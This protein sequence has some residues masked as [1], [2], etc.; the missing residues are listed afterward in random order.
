MRHGYPSDH[1]GG[2][3]NLVSASQGRSRCASTKIT[4]NVWAWLGLPLQMSSP[5]L[6]S[7]PL[8]APASPCTHPQTGSNTNRHHAVTPRNQERQEPGTEQNQQEQSNCHQLLL[9]LSPTVSRISHQPPARQSCRPFVSDQ[10]VRSL[11]HDVRQN[12]LACW[13]VA[14]HD[15]QPSILAVILSWP[16]NE[17]Q[18][19]INTGLSY[20]ATFVELDKCQKAAICRNNQAKTWS[21]HKTST[22]KYH[23][24]VQPD[25]KKSQLASLKLL[26]GVSIAD[27]KR[28]VPKVNDPRPQPCLIVRM[29]CLR[30]ACGVINDSNALLVQCENDNQNIMC[31]INRLFPNQCVLMEWE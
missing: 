10:C 9:L 28:W 2:K 23:L 19:P 16:F 17:M 18:L 8:P 11:K 24:F 21:A 6:G 12:K 13:R 5:Q 7:F 25:M 27:G 3:I 20:D 22:G 30:K 26:N 14:A 4:Q 1:S 29:N 31:K 15:L